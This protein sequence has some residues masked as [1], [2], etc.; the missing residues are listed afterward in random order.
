MSLKPSNGL[1]WRISDDSVRLIWLSKKAD[2]SSGFFL[3]IE[4]RLNLVSEVL[5]IMQI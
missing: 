3:E 2:K 4:F 5:G 1:S